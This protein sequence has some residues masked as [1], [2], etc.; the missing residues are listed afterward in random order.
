MGIETKLRHPIPQNMT[1]LD[2]GHRTKEIN[3]KQ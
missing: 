2:T 1:I 3:V